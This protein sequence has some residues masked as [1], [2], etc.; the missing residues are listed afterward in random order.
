MALN[1]TVLLILGVP[2]LSPGEIDSGA[3][4]ELHFADGVI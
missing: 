4:L 1:L 3:P 2:S